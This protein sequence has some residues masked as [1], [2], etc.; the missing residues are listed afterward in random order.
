MREDP[1]RAWEPVLRAIVE[2]CLDE[3]P[4]L[5]ESGQGAA[6][7]ALKPDGDPTIAAELYAE[8]IAQTILSRQDNPVTLYSEESEYL[9]KASDARYIVLLDPIDA[10]FLAVRRLP[11]SCVG[12]S[13][14]EA[15]RMEPVA[16]MVGDYLTADVYWATA[17]GAFKNGERIRPSSVTTLE[18]AYISTCYGKATRIGSILDRKGLIGSAQW[19]ETT[20]GILSMVLVGTGQIDAYLDLM[21]GYKSYDV[22]PGAYIARMAGAV[23]TDEEGNDLRYPRDLEVRRKFIIAANVELHA[24]IIRAAAE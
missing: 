1:G 20:G 17:E 3:V 23:V 6:V 8:R 19:I 9:L 10:T 22:A 13:V 12:I 15:N 16:A 14:H 18:H 24:K 2:R 11:G 4:G 5:I 21:L 7:T